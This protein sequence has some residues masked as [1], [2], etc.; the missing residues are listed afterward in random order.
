MPDQKISARTPVTTILPGD[1]APLI[2]PSDT[3]DPDKRIIGADLLAQVRA[4]AR[5]AIRQMPPIRSGRY[6][7]LSPA[8]LTAA[9]VTADH[10]YARVIEVLEDMPVT[11]FGANITAAPSAGSNGCLGAIFEY[12]P[13]TGFALGLYQDD[14]GNYIRTPSPID[15]AVPNN[16]SS[17]GTP[18]AI[19]SS[20]L[21]ATA[22]LKRGVYAQVSCFNGTPSLS[23]VNPADRWA[24][25]RLGIDPTG[26][27]NPL[28]TLTGERISGYGYTNFANNFIT[29]ASPTA[30]LAGQTWISISSEPVLALRAA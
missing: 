9:A 22:I 6:Y 18:A 15:T 8:A 2:R 10:L 26:Q 16:T 5:V 29:P 14:S 25:S 28:A 27:T 11:A 12:D 3:S 24:V 7:P 19:R 1:S 21:A 23:C 30:T 17:G 4:E 20:A 13:T